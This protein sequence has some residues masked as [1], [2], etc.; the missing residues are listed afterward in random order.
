MLGFAWLAQRQARQ[1]LKHGR[2]E[3]AHRLLAPGGVPARSRA[4]CLLRQ[5]ARAYV[6]RGERHLKHDQPEAAWTDLLHAEQLGV[7][8]SGAEKLRQALAR[9]GLAEVRA[10]LQAGQP[11]RAVEAAGQLRDRLVNQPE[12]VVLEE[13]ARAWLEVSE[14]AA[15]GDHALALATVE[16]ARRLAPQA[17]EALGRLREDVERRQEAFT[18]L[19]AR[20]HEAAEQGR[21]REVAELAERVLGLAPQHGEARH[22]RGRAWKALEPVTLPAPA[23]SARTT[24]SGG[25]ANGPVE[26]LLLWIDGVGAY[27]V[28]LGPRVTIGQATADAT[29]DV[30][31]FAD[32]SRLH[33]VLTRDGEGY[34]LEAARSVQVNGRP[35]EKTLLR[36]GDRI[37]L[38]ASC[39]LSFRKPAAVSASARLD[40]TSGHR[41]P[42]AVDGILLMADTLLLGPGPQAHVEMPDLE[43]P[44]VLFRHKDGLG[45]R[46]PGALTIN[47]ERC[48][49]RG[50]LGPH[51]T[52]A[53]EEFA[54]AVEAVGAR[55]GELVR[56][57]WFAVPG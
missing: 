45:V 26:R 9:L 11:G 39:E 35:A 14:L 43:K 49:D 50:L 53:G 27:L 37:A 55:M 2:L 5:L 13:A 42:L 12:L 17:A 4:G 28:C 22:L 48:K 54:F 21:W 23:A 51:A 44:V 52:V 30:P 31:L 47:G 46:C 32:V 10:L 3:E 16:R 20:L 25:V 41:L 8:D 7:D 33:A 24:R 19:L 15:R 36:S 38:G 57:S 1:A 18:P 40:V 56:G 34:L 29:V 6:E